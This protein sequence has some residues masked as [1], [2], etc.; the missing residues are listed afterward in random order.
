MGSEV[1]ISS[2]ASSQRR[3]R[4]KGQAAPELP[5]LSPIK[6]EGSFVQSRETTFNQNPVLPPIRPV[7]QTLAV[8][9]TGNALVKA[10]I[11]STAAIHLG[12]GE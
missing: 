2:A 7:V 10:R 6:D 1:S 3:T 11:K 12:D 9:G 5:P 8:T 4:E